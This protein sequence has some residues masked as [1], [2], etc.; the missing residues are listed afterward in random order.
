MGAATMKFQGF[1]ALIEALV[2]EGHVHEREAEMAKAV[3]GMMAKP[4]ATGEP[5]LSLPLTVQDRRLSA[6]PIV[7]MEVPVVSWDEAAR[8]P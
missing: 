8:V 1:F 6:G 7:L 3:L 4:S 2:Q 5:E